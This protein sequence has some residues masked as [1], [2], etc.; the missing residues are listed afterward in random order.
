MTAGRFSNAQ[1]LALRLIAK[2]GEVATLKTRVDG[3][4]S[5]STK[6]W[7]PATPT[8]TSQ[9]V[10]A[11]FLGDT[12][13][14]GEGLVERK[15]QEVWIAATDPGLTAAPEANDSQIVR[16]SGETFEVVLVE[17]IAPNE[18]MIVYRLEVTR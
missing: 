5:D 12:E 9:S 2:N 18:D 14:R 8:T 10:N 13:A 16:A 7:E 3:T 4:P 6:P 11:V 1:A 17:I 15:V